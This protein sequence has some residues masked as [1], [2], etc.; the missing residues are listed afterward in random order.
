MIKAGGVVGDTLLLATQAPSQSAIAGKARS[1]EYPTYIYRYTRMRSGTGSQSFLRKPVRV[2]SLYVARAW[3]I[4]LSRYVRAEYC[5]RFSS[6]HFRAVI[7]NHLPCNYHVCTMVIITHRG[8]EVAGHLTKNNT[9]NIENTVKVLKQHRTDLNVCP[10]FF[11][12]L[13]FKI[14]FFFGDSK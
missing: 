6:R 9:E 11:H 13:V 12:W 10:L 7:L 2:R 3:T 14:T 4:S 8:N 1:F 5:W